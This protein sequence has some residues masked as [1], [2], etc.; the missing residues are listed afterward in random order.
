MLSQVL[1]RLLSPR[2]TPARRGRPSLTEDV[3]VWIIVLSLLSWLY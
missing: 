2:K 3:F 1:K